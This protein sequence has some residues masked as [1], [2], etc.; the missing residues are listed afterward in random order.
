MDVMITYQINNL[1]SRGVS[2]LNAFEEELRQLSAP[3][4][5]VARDLIGEAAGELAADLF[6]TRKAKGFGKKATKAWLEGQKWDN[7]KA[8]TARY[9]QQYLQWFQET[10]QLVSGISV[11]AP[12]LIFPGNCASLLRKVKRAEGFKK[13]DTRIRHV[14]TVLE[15]L[16]THD[17]VLNAS[18]PKQIAAPKEEA[19]FDP[20]QALHKLEDMLRRFIERELSKTGADWWTAR[21]PLDIRSRAESRKQKQETVW[22]WHLVSSTNVMDYLDFSDYRRI[23]LDSTNW[24]QVFSGFFRASSFVDSRMGELEPIRN[25]LAHSRPLSAMT[26]NKARLYVEELE[27]CTNRTGHGV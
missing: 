17:L 19:K 21:V 20:A 11:S 18:L 6:G 13:L 22:P 14:I 12:H 8:I 24:S 2:L 25:D 3:G 27:K 10:C 9:Y 26:C 5:N 16:R 15:E 7:A 1:I 4:T 23:I